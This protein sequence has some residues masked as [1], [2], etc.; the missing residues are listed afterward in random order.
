M[1]ISSPRVITC[2]YVIGFTWCVAALSFAAMQY[3]AWSFQS[4]TVDGMLTIAPAAKSKSVEFLT[5]PVQ[6][7]IVDGEVSFGRDMYLLLQGMLSAQVE[8]ARHLAMTS[9]LLWIGP[10]VVFGALLWRDRR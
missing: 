4:R 9:I 5:D 1:K 6:K 3:I 10:A 2:V 8:S 7:K